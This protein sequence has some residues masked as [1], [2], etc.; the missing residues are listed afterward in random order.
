MAEPVEKDR[1]ILKS[2]ALELAKPANEAGI[3]TGTEVVVFELCGECH[4][5]ESAVVRE[6]RR[7]SGVTSLP[8]VPAFVMGIMNV[9]GEILSVVDLGKLFGLPSVPFSDPA[10]VVVLSGVGMTFGIAVHALRGTVRIPL[11]G[12]QRA[13]VSG[14]GVAQ[15]IVRGVMPDRLIVL[16]GAALLTEKALIV[17]AG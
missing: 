11:Q 9:R 15:N 17:D 8:G 4:A 12:L 1:A 13:P 14:T 3:E 2:R 5:V 10:R 6:I 16:D 7:L